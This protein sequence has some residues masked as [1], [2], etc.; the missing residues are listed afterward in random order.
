MSV[1]QPAVI[2]I[3]DLR[4]ETYAS[5]ETISESAKVPMLYAI[6]VPRLAT[7]VLRAA[8]FA[9]GLQIASIR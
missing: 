1:R 6:H 8:G 7:G 9:D 3:P 5:I 2:E 4:S